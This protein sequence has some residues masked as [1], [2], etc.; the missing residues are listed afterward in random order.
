MIKIMNELETGMNEVMDILR[1]LLIIC[2]WLCIWFYIP[3]SGYVT[4]NGRWSVGMKWRLV[5]AVLILASM[6]IILWVG[7]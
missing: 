5:R 6:L 7:I 4:G 1:F 2:I 3:L